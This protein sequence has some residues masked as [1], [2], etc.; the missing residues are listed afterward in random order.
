MKIN[1]ILIKSDN[2]Y[3]AESEDRFPLSVLCKK[4]KIPTEIA[5]S[6]P[7]G[8]EWH[9]SSM[10]ANEVKYYDLELVEEWLTTE[11]GKAAMV[12]AKA[13]HSNKDIAIHENQEVHWL[14]W[15]GTRKHPKCNEREAAP[16]R[17]EV[18]KQTATV[19]FPSGRKM[20]KRLTTEGFNFRPVKPA[21]D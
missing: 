21:T 7:W 18:K 11:D 9:H 5:P 19:T 20:V 16:C 12:E 4:L 14:D 2:A 1:G 3:R 17:V 10:Y 8:G 6:L 15:Y 13:I